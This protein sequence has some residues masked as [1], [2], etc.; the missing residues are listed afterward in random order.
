MD[1]QRLHQMGDMA[2]LFLAA[3]KDNEVIAFLMAFTE[4]AEY[5]SVNYR[6][7]SS[8]YQDFLYIDR[9]IVLKEVRS[10]GIGRTFYSEAEDWARKRELNWLTAEVDVK[11]P[12]T[13]SL[14]FHRK[15]NFKE[16]GRQ[17]IDNGK[18]VSLLAKSIR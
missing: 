10:R 6:W 3:E 7:F 18:T 16:V 17:T 9:V 4:G 15:Q 1:S 12:N 8:R 14:N 11:P 2:A 5:D 13:A